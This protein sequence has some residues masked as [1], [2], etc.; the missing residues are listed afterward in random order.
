MPV[1]HCFWLHAMVSTQQLPAH[2]FHPTVSSCRIHHMFLHWGGCA[3][4]WFPQHSYQP[5]E[6]PD[7]FYGS[8]H[9]IRPHGTKQG[10]ARRAVVSFIINI[11]MEINFSSKVYSTGCMTS[12][13]IRYNVYILKDPKNF[14]NVDNCIIVQLQTKDQLMMDNT[15]IN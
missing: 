7:G 15:G 8:H 12:L 1:C 2:G 5:M 9:L 13:L 11:T 6:P 4:I 10:K 3:F 14:M